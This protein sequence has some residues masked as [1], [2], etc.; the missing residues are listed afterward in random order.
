M[1]SEYMVRMRYLAFSTTREKGPNHS[2]Y[3]SKINAKYILTTIAN[4]N[5][6]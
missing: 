6:D 5:D 1:K 4:K 2:L 3:S